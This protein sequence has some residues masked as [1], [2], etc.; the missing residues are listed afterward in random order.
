MNLAKQI[1]NDKFGYSSPDDPARARQ[2]NLEGYGSENKGAAKKLNDFIR[3]GI[4]TEQIDKGDDIIKAL[5]SR[6]D[7]EH[8]EP[9]KADTFLVL[10]NE[11]SKKKWKT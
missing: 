8:V 7:V 4:W 1:I 5:Q 6:D 9:N 2:I 3:N 10:K 11:R